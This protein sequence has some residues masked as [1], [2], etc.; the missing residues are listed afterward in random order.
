DWPPDRHFK[1]IF[2]HHYLAFNQAFPDSCADF[3]RA[4]G[5]ANL[6]ACWPETEG[7]PDLG[8]K[9]YAA[10]ANHE[11]AE[12]TTR[13]H[14]DV[15]DAAN[16]MVW[17]AD[18]SRPAARWHIFRRA[19]AATL[20]DGI[21]AAKWCAKEDH[22]IHSQ[23]V[24]LKPAMLRHLAERHGVRPWIID[25]SVGDL[26]IVPAGAAHQ[27]LNKQGAIKLASDFIS[28]LNAATTARMVGELR[29]SRIKAQK[30]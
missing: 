23:S 18:Q 27:V 7:A 14:L 20:Q 16:L 5:V 19:D 25:Q 10:M 13:L 21:R 24:Y 1:D 2:R 9:M 6:A 12:G 11:D 28:V 4:N 17:A 3:V 22:P 26:V 15:T 29:E 8:P 30:P